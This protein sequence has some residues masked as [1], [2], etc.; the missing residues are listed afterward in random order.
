MMETIN[1][2]YLKAVGIVTLIGGVAL[3]STTA[4]AS[5]NSTGSLATAQTNSVAGPSLNT[6]TSEIPEAG[7]SE[8]APG[9]M[10]SPNAP[11]AGEAVD[12]SN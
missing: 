2:R 12:S 6:T 9:S 5:D 10:D 8:Q 1:K 4:F 7:D 3:L 11:Q